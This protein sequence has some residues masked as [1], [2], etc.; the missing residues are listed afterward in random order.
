MTKL[1]KEDIHLIDTFLNYWSIKSVQDESEMTFDEALAFLERKEVKVYM[2]ERSNR[3]EA[4]YSRMPKALYLQIVMN[5]VQHVMTN[6]ATAT[7]IKAVMDMF[8]T[9]YR[10]APPPSS[11]EFA[12]AIATQLGVKA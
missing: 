12:E 7:E 5:R 6:Q 4:M 11:S 2:E 1:T 10:E 9:Y 3:L 8:L